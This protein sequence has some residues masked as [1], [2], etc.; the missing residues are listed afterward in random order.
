M[1][2]QIAF[3]TESGAFDVVNEFETDIQDLA[4]WCDAREEANNWAEVCY[5]G[6]DW[7]VLQN[8]R[9]VNA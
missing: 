9:N 3:Q 7:Y 2:F 1:T 5:P 6:Q 4:E 8:G